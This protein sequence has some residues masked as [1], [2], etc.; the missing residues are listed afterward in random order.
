M[1]DKFKHLN[2]KDVNNLFDSSMKLNDNYDKTVT[3]LEYDSVIES[4][5]YVMH[6]T[7]FDITFVICRLS[8]YISKLNMNQLKAIAK[9]FG[10]L[11]R[12][13][14]FGLFYYDFVVVLEGYCDASSSNNKSTSIWISSF[15]GGT[16]SLVSKKQT[17]IS[18]SPM[19]S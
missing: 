8:R 12:T 1:L 13:I 17:C 9:V 16:I 19:K 5:M 7:R 2:I 4:L 10:Y 18:H 11:K 3:Q 15:E 6:C 14:D